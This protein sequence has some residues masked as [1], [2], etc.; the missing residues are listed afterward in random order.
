VADTEMAHALNLGIGMV[1]VLPA[2]QADRAV[3]FLAG[4]GV[5]ARVIGEVVA[6]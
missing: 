1:A 2:D 4:R 3:R 5:G 6:G